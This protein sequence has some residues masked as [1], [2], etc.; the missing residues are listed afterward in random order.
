MS[1]HVDVVRYLGN[2]CGY[3]YIEVPLPEG[4][5][6]LFGFQ[7]CATD[8]W[9]SQTLKSLGLRLLPKIGEA[10]PIYFPYEELDELD[11]EALLLLDNLDLIS[12]GTGW[13]ASFIQFRIENLRSAIASAKEL[14]DKVG[15]VSIG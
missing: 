2:G 4:R 13:E 1:L 7:K 11:R 12:Q 10:K 8:L 3:E 5:N 14:P 9:G 6:G 15:G